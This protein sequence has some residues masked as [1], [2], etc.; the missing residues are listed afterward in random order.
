MDFL[1]LLYTLD[2]PIAFSGAH[3][4]DSWQPYIDMVEGMKPEAEK[5]ETFLDIEPVKIFLLPQVLSP[6]RILIDST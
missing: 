2:A 5:H 6:L 3:F 1:Y 4:F